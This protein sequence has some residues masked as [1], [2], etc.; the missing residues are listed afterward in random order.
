[1]SRA[2]VSISEPGRC[3]ALLAHLDVSK[4]IPAHPLGLLPAPAWEGGAE[5]IHVEAVHDRSAVRTGPLCR[6]PGVRRVAMWAY[7]QAEAAGGPKWGR[8]GG[9]VLP[10]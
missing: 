5:A 3:R 1:M 10:V 4:R 2:Q 8:A 7:A 6:R 9:K